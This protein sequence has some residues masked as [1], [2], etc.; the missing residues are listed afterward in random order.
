MSNPFQISFSLRQHTPIIH[1]Q[2]D[3][4]GATLRATEVKPKLDMFIIQHVTG[5]IGHEAVQAFE[6]CTRE[7]MDDKRVNKNP[8]FNPLWKDW[9]IG[10]GRAEHVALDYKMNFIAGE[11]DN[12]LSGPIEHTFE[13]RGQEK[14]E[15][16]PGFFGAM[17][18][19][20]TGKK[21]FLQY[22]GVEVRIV[23]W[24]KF[25]LEQIR[26]AIPGFFMKNNFGNRQS[27]G[28]GS[29]YPE[30]QIEY[31]ITPLK[32]YFDV[33]VSKVQKPFGNYIGKSPSEKFKQ[34][35]RLFEIINLFY[36]TLRSGI[37]QSWGSNPIYFKS[38][39]FMYAKNRMGVQWDKKIIKEKLFH[40]KIVEHQR[41][42]PT[43]EML[44]Y[45]S[46][47]SFLLRD[48]LGLA[49]ESQWFAEY[50]DTIFTK[51]NTINGD[52]IDRFKSPILFK[53]INFS[54][55]KFH[56]YFEANQSSLNG[57]LNENFKISSKTKNKSFEIK[58]P[59]KF[60]LDDFLQYTFSIDISNHIETKG[61]SG[62]SADKELLIE[63]YNQ[64]RTNAGIYLYK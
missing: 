63:I 12:E 17:G 31:P 42:H 39:M 26:K 29:F 64:V 21:E 56:I 11:I 54:P 7:Y 41:K 62:Y 3:Q 44:N 45:S 22:N 35:F 27:K 16:F 55:S 51:S 5:K 6:L 20:N 13:I 18:E 59:P 49:S 50:K 1:F 9:L 34:Y 57:I 38:M 14:P 2:H 8:N 36:S 52:Q 24:D 43:S 40:D 37:N 53:P 15:K 4:D 47:D 61:G 33:D 28:F 19:E 25:L 32:Y 10:K 58:T 23:C 30:S 60:N 46:R 48:L